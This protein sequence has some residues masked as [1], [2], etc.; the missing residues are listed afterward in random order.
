M[1]WPEGRTPSGW[2]ERMYR[3]TTQVMRTNVGATQGGRM[4]E[5]DGVAAA[6]TPSSPDRSVFNSVFYER[7]EAL[8]AAL[9]ELAAGYERAG[10]RAWTVWVPDAD[11]VSAELLESA[12][13]RLDATPTAMVL[14]MADL[15]GIEARDLDWD[16]DAPI[17]EVWRI[18]DLA[19]GFPPGTFERGLG[20]PPEGSYRFYLARLDGKPA[21]VVGTMDVDGD[22]GVY[23]VATLP[24]A[25]GR[26]L[27]TRLMRA[28]VAEGRERG[29]DISTLQATT[30]GRPIYERLGYRDTGTLQMWERRS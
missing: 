4:L 6:L 27:T 12:G 29:C 17:E 2:H 22:C 14:D 15:P 7:P 25:R 20:R 16:S 23:W 9:D 21:C 10:V 18:N 8:A 13:H 30:L 28:A 1:A 3:S 11:R 26:G 24:E 5:S 19:Y